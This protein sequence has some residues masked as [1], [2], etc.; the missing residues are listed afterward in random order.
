MFNVRDFGAV[1]DGITLNTL[2]IQKTIDACAGA[3]GGVVV[4][5]AGVFVIGP[6]ELKSNVTLHISAGATLLGTADPRLYQPA[7]GIPLK[8]D[9]TMGDGNVALIYAANAENV[10]VEGPG[11]ID[12]QGAQVIAN[13]RH[14]GRRAHLLLF[15]RCKNLSVRNVY[16]YHS[17]FH[18]CRI[19]NCTFVR[20]DSIHIFSRT[21]GNND[22]FHFISAQ[23]VTLSNCNVQCGDDACAMFG[24]CQFMTITNS[25]FS[26]R[27]STFRFGGGIARNIAV[28]NCVCYQVYGCPIKLRCAPGSIYE[29]MSFSD[30][31]FQD[32][33]GPISIGAGPEHLRRRRHENPTTSALP[34]GIVR[35][36][37]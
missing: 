9:W 19:A 11:T 12:G 28:S 35:N 27:W 18:T 34:G 16:L 23:Y 8:G 15:Y 29:N 17:S 21:V 10:S 31:V 4:V 37:S 3:G 30:L 22:G 1:G 14:G 13:R 5:P 24:S 32:V 6:I 20:L 33:T 7:A 26:T 2:A 36:I 25:T